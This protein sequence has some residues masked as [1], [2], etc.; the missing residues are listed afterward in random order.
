MTILETIDYHSINT[1]DSFYDAWF[2]PTHRFDSLKTYITFLK[3][4]LN[5]PYKYL[6]DTNLIKLNCRDTLVADIAIKIIKEES[7]IFHFHSLTSKNPNNY[8]SIIVT[9]DSVSIKK[10][11]KHLKPYKRSILKKNL[12]AKFLKLWESLAKSIFPQK[13]LQ[14]KPTKVLL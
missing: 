4:L 7:I 11:S 9:K 3:D 6:K 12:K 5:N 1:I 10:S 13:S 14:Y 8:R 2:I